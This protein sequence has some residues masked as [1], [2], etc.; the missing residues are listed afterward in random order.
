MKPVAA[1][2]VGGWLLGNVIK[3]S[4]IDKNLQRSEMCML[5]AELLTDLVYLV[6]DY[7]SCGGCLH[8]TWALFPVMTSVYVQI[9]L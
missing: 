7:F 1:L 4:D 9:I 6:Q 8:Y 3:I 2:A 5:V